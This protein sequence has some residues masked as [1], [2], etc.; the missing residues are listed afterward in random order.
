MGFKINKSIIQGTDAHRGNIESSALKSKSYSEAKKA[1]PNL[2][3][4]IKARKTVD[5]G[6]DEYNKIQNQI[7]KA[8]GVGKRHGKPKTNTP[9][10]G[11]TKPK[12]TTPKN[13]VVTG[14]FKDKNKNRKDD[15]SEKTTDFTGKKQ[16]E[17]G[18]GAAGTAYLTGLGAKSKIGQKT[19][20]KAGLKTGAKIGAKLGARAI[21]FLGQALM[22][23]DLAKLG[24]YSV[25]K[26]S[27][28]EGAKDLG[29]DYGLTF[30]GDTPAKKKIPVD[31][32]KEFDL[33]YTTDVTAGNR[34]KIKEM[35]ANYKAGKITKKQLKEAIKEI[36][37]YEDI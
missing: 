21:P 4:L 5:K 6:S 25:K 22:A 27:F 32:S 36:S 35:Q 26:G 1:N 2:D 16:L 34:K 7:N 13:K 29:R 3:K 20:T 24:Y 37:S 15:R 23:Y 30:D 19:L 12:T 28:K 9:G 14:D 33:D 18:A 31:K 10:G 17:S 11:G 8:Y